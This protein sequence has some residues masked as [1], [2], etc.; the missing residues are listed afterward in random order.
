MSFIAWLLILLLTL[1]MVS[2][3]SN[4]YC[5]LVPPIVTLSRD[6]AVL[7]SIWT[8]L[9]NWWSLR[10]FCNFAESAEPS[11]KMGNLAMVNAVFRTLNL[12]C[13]ANICWMVYTFGQPHKSHIQRSDRQPAQVHPFVHC[14]LLDSP[15]LVSL[16][17]PVLPPPKFIEGSSR[18]IT[19]ST[20]LDI[21]ANRWKAS[22]SIDS[23]LGFLRHQQQHILLIYNLQ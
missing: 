22:A 14:L 8:I 11:L 7:S 20:E 21:L 1:Y 4:L 5:I 3:M 2:D 10:L 9:K 18:G 23:L 6:F 19:Y 16:F 17:L 15:I 12:S 13:S